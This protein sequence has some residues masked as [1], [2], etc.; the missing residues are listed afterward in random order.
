MKRLIAGAAAAAA[1][2]AIP[3]G[4]ST[5]NT[6]H[7]AT[8]AP[9]RCVRRVHFSVLREERG[10]I[11]L[12]QTCGAHQAIRARAECFKDHTSTHEWRDGDW[13]TRNRKSSTAGCQAGWYI[14]N[15]GYQIDHLSTYFVLW[16][17][18]GIPLTQTG[19]S[20]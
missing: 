10:Y 16:R 18:T 2:T 6:A 4:V 13:R 8:A 7:A 17:Y 3:V 5:A 11:T 1:I 20:K 12:Y 14:D 19:A 15:G 9:D